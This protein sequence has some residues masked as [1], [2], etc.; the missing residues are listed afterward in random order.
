M[1][2]TAS[3][4]ADFTELAKLQEKVNNT[5][6][7][8]ELRTKVQTMIERA[9]LAFKYHSQF[10]QFDM[11]DDYIDWVTSLPWKTKSDDHLDIGEAKKILDKNHYGLNELKDR[12][13]EYLSVMKL[14]ID[15]A[16]TSTDQ[17]HNIARAP[18]FFFVGLVGTGKTTMAISIADALGRKF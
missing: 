17:V 12:I 3:K 1:K 18:I 4:S 14:N 10:S 15:L 16:K 11:V 2:D 5:P 7:P 8:D 9:S 13:L 6:L